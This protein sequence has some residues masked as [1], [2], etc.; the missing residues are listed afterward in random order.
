M[1]VS[2]F[3]QEQFQHVQLVIVVDVEYIHCGKYCMDETME[4]KTCW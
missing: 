3:T 2:M 1:V 4:K